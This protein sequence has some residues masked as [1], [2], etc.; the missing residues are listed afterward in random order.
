MKTVYD[1]ISDNNKKTFLLLLLFPVS[2]I[3]LVYLAVIASAYM[4]NDPYFMMAGVETLKSIYS[5]VQVDIDDRHKVYLL[6]ALGITIYT[7]VPII[8]AAMLWM[9][10]SYFFGDKMMLKF[11][12]AKAGEQSKDIKVYQ[13]VEN[14]AIMAGLPVPKVYIMEDAGMN[15]F[16]TGRDPSHAS[17]ALTR[18][19]IDNLDMPELEAVIGH[20]MAHIQNRDIRLNMLIITGLGVFGFLSSMFRHANLGVGNGGNSKDRGKTVVLLIFVMIALTVF[21]Y[22]VAPLIRM[23]VS[24]TREYAADATGAL[25]VRNPQA[26]ASALRKIGGKSEVK[27]VAKEKDMAAAFIAN[28]LKQTSMSLINLSNTHPPL[29]QRIERLEK[30]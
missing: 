12:N 30:M 13:A 26:L 11:A 8:V 16:A 4:I 24:R 29:E 22:L 15:A 21:H 10:A 25:L 9:L 27:A 3:I 28:P 6:G 2:L 1:H 18:G 23:A 14:V 7:T 20:E 5:D 17:I 19:L